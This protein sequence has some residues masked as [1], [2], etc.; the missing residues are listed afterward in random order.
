M[1]RSGMV[2][3]GLG[4]LGLFGY[5]FFSDPS[6]RDNGAKAKDA[7]LH[8]GDTVRDKGVASLVDLRFKAK[9]GFDATCFLH[10]YYDDGRVLIYGLI[11]PQI[12]A[13]ALVSEAKEVPGVR[14]AEAVVNPT[15]VFAL[16]VPAQSEAPAGAAP[17][18][19]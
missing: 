7:A 16:P 11:P 14:E 12:T 18:K 9:Y 10:T 1:I 3:A 5:Y 15:P 19:P 13:D 17:A 6:Q 8:V 4:L 2:V